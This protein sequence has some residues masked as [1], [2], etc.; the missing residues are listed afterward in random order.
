MLGRAFRGRGARPATAARRRLSAASAG[1]GAGASVAYG[2]GGAQCS[3]VAVARPGLSSD[4]MGMIQLFNASRDSVA[5]IT[6]LTSQSGMQHISRYHDAAVPQGTGSGFVW[7]QVSEH[8]P[9]IPLQ[10]G[11]SPLIYSGNPGAI[12]VSHRVSTGNARGRAE[13]S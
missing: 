8:S 10:K 7:D 4:E 2:S 9:L 11:H 6:N 12:G 5:F 1:A 13:S 3:P